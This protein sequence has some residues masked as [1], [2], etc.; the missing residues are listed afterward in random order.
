MELN[1]DNFL[2]KTAKKLKKITRIG[3]IIL[4][5][6]FVIF[7]LFAYYGSYSTGVRAGKVIKVS[8]RGFIF[9]TWEG[10]LDIESF[11]AI[12]NSNN[13]FTQTFDFSVLNDETAK[14]LEKAALSGKRVN[15]HYTE[16]YIKLPWR[17]ETKYFVDEVEY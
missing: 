11:G 8:K 14:E 2:N 1:N 3:L 13:Q 10:Q 5:L 12:K 9:K 4:I 15:L 7:M 6:V 17:G 16:K